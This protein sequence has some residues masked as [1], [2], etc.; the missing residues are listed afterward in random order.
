VF[1]IS[2]LSIFGL[3]A[4]SI[5]AAALL[6]QLCYLSGWRQVAGRLR[7]LVRSSLVLRAAQEL[8]DRG[9]G[10][11]AQAMNLKAEVLDL[12]HMHLEALIAANEERRDA[13]DVTPTPV[14]LMLESEANPEF[15]SSPR[16][17][18]RGCPAPL[19]TAR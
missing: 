4:G 2:R 10:R 1:A 11:P 7:R 15:R 5:C 12:G 9:F 8:L 19:W 14:P 17:R 13:I 3:L 16:C 18:R 6:P